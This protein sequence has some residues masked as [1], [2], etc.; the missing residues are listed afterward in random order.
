MGVMARQH[1]KLLNGTVVEDRMISK[2]E[3]KRN[4]AKA[5][6]EAS[7]SLDS[8]MVNAFKNAGGDTV[9]VKDQVKETT[10]ETT[11]EK[12][13][14]KEEEVKGTLVTNGLSLTTKGGSTF[15]RTLGN[16]LRSSNGVINVT[17][18]TAELGKANMVKDQVVYTAP[19]VTVNSLIDYIYIEA[20]NGTGATYKGNVFELYL[21]VPK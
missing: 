20:N 15:S 9:L 3:Y 14:E 5:I 13:E 4:K 7:T 17:T 18:I 8:V 1:I 2:A 19:I 21:Y 12:E 10:V 16:I 6:R 11:V